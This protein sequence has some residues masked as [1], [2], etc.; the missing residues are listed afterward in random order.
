MFCPA[1]G[2]IKGDEIQ[3]ASIYKQFNDI[4]LCGIMG[5]CGK[6]ANRLQESDAA[7]LSLRLPRVDEGV[8]TSAAGGCWKRLAEGLSFMRVH[9]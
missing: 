9:F 7:G 4:G 5:V 2:E 1:E 6:T 3:A 8:A